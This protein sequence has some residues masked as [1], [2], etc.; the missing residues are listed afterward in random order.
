MPLKNYRWFIEYFSTEEGHL[1]GIRQVLFSIPELGFPFPGEE[2]LVRVGVPIPQP[3]L[4]SEEGLLQLVAYIQGLKAPGG[5][6]APPAPGADA[7]AGDKTQVLD[8]GSR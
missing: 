5:G 4:G 2:H 8:P 3:G 1:H 6:A 7:P